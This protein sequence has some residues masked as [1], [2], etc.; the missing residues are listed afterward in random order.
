ME[1]VM[2]RRL[3]PDRDVSNIKTEQDVASLLRDG[4][5]LCELMNKI[6]PGSV[7]KYHRRPSAFQQM[8]N[9]EL[10]LKACVQYGMDKIDTFQVKELYEARAIYLV[11]NCLYALGSLA[12]QNGFRGPKLGVKLA[13]R[14][15]RQF[16]EEQ[17]QDARR[18]ISRQ[19]SGP[20]G[21]PTQA[22]MTP[23]GMSRQILMSGDSL[24]DVAT[25]SHA[26]IGLQYGSNQVASQAGMTAYGMPR[27][28]STS[29]LSSDDTINGSPSPRAKGEAIIGLQ[30]GSNRVA[31][32]SR[33]TA[34]GMPRQIVSSTSSD[35][36]P[37]SKAD[38]DPSR[39]GDDSVFTSLDKTL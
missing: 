8:E 28:I 22:R 29:S 10:F 27:Q 1:A 24:S 16:S 38:D 34:Y 7:G 19:N 13:S 12:Q 15:Q 4:T 39:N 20:P 21:G 9:V 26:V 32:Q 37:S 14:N 31:S 23:Y 25:S 35:F 36:L 18:S 17:K 11:I 3:A 30:Y 5:A 33:M 2:D 6:S